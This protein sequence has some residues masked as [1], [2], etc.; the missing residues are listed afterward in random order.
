MNHLSRLLGVTA[1][2]WMADIIKSTLPFL[3]GD[4][5]IDAAFG[6]TLPTSDIADKERAKVALFAL[7]REENPYGLFLAHFSDIDKQGHEF[8]VRCVVPVACRLRV[9]VC[10]CVCVCVCVFV[11]VCVCMFACV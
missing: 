8:G 9:F 3:S 1:S 5:T 2:P 7:T 6:T 4:G 11:C 10:A